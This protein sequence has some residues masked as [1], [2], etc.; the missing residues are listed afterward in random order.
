[1]EMPK[2][3]G[4][5]MT[6]LAEGIPS[7]PLEALIKKMLPR[8]EVQVRRPEAGWRVENIGTTYDGI[9]AKLTGAKKTRKSRRGAI[10]VCKYKV[11]NAYGQR[12]HRHGTWTRAMVDAALACDNSKDAQQHLVDHYPKFA[13]RKIDWNW[14]ANDVGYIELL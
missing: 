1:M 5:R 13:D 10:T 6:A 12:N 8:R 2:D 11:I 14:L 7:Q 9:T 4:K 3:F